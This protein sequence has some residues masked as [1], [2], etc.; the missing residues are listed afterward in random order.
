[1]KTIIKWLDQFIS[2][3]LSED[4]EKLNDC[5]YLLEGNKCVVSESYAKC[6]Y[7]NLNNCGEQ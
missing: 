4:E 1:M 5:R 3:L 2:S 7:D 6:T